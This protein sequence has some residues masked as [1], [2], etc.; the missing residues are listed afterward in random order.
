MSYGIGIVVAM[1]SFIL[2]RALFKII[3]YKTVITYSPII[4]ELLKSM[5][6]YFIGADILLVH[7]TFGIIEGA[8]EFFQG[9]NRIGKFA[10]FLSIIGH[11]LFGLTVITILMFVNNIYFAVLSSTLLHLLWNIIVVKYF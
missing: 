8:Y 10:A 5:P 11:F 1:I 3:G 2:N 9:S 6:A 4:E 7:I